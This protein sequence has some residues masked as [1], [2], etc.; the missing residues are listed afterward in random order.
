ML[1]YTGRNR[2]LSYAL[3]RSLVEAG[4][5]VQMVCLRDALGHTGDRAFY[6]W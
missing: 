3:A 2:S 5:Q 1:L 4:H 6:R